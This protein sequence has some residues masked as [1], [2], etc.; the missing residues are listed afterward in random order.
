MLNHIFH[1]LLMLL[2][3]LF[4]LF[5]LLHRFLNSGR[6]Y[7]LSP[8]A[9]YFFFLIIISLLLQG[10]FQCLYPEILFFYSLIKCSFRR[11]LLT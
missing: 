6:K 7:F 1:S 2:Y 9:D 4:H 3:R 8:P 5:L 11:C 10:S